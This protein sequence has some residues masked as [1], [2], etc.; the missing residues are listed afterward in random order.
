MKTKKMIRK[1]AL[2]KKTISDLDKLE[3][4]SVRGGVSTCDTCVTCVIYC[5]TC[6]TVCIPC[7]TD[8][9]IRCQVSGSPS[10]PNETCY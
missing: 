6:Q 8:N 1:L 5:G 7:P 10:C 2:N 4:S 9:P 3:Q